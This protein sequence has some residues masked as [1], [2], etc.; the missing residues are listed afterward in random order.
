MMDI[1]Y[2]SS[3][4][5][6]LKLL[7]GNYRLQTGDLFDYEWDYSETSGRRGGR[8]TAFSRGIITKKLILGVLGTSKEDYYKALNHFHNTVEADVLNG[9][10]G[11]LWVGDYYLRCYVISSQKSE[12]E[13]DIELLDNE[14]ELVTEYPFWCKETLYSF[15]KSASAIQDSIFDDEREDIWNGS[16]VTKDYPF[17]Y[18]RDFQSKIKVRLKRPNFDYPMDFKA[19]ATYGKIVNGHYAPCN[20]KM[21]VYGPC[22]NP[23]V[24]I[25][26][27]IYEVRTILYDGEYM[28]LNT[29]DETIIKYGTNG[30][31]TNLFNQRNKEYSVFKKISSGYN[32]VRWS[33]LFGFDLIMV[34]ER[35]EPAWSL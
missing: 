11:K 8:I 2:E 29:Q 13:Y 17:D 19:K 5:T 9:S 1:Y 31:K 7:E 12:W 33:A 18:P 22:T 34:E 32:S 20:F 14:I 3:N 15:Y 16:E 21:I 26:N 23:A 6:T 24:R 25:N 10:P 28:V 27:H 30:V 35:S 4:G